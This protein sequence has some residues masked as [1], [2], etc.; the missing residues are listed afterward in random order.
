VAELKF[1]PLAQGAA[2]TTVIAAASPGNKHKV[3]GITLSLNNDGTWR[4][5][6]SADL[7][8]NI[9]QDGQ[10]QPVVIGPSILPFVETALG[11]ALSIVTTQVAQ[12]VVQFVTEP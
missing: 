8:G 11:A 12:G 4:L 6:G 10:L 5:T 9:K 2:G 3:L 1:F 7:T